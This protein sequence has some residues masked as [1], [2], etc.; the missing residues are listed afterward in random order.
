MFLGRLAPGV[1][2]LIS[3]PAG[4]AAMP[5]PAFLA[6]TTAGTALW[7]ALLAGAGYVLDS[8]YERVQGWTNPAANLVFA[9]AVA[10][11]L[12]RVATWR[13]RQAGPR[14]GD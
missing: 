10:V 7:T 14:V 11:Y 5:W 13:R 6:W 3:V 1:R 12:Y 8:Q 2:T 9:A 4:V